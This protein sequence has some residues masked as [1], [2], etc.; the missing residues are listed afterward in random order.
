LAIEY[1]FTYPKD[2]DAEKA[3]Q[4]FIQKWNWH[5]AGV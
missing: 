2:Q 1:R 4:E 3:I 5:E